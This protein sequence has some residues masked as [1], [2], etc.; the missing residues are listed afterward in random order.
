MTCNRT[1]TINNLLVALHAC[2]CADSSSSDLPNRAVR[3]DNAYGYICE[4]LRAIAAHVELE[5]YVTTGDLV[6]Y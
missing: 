1:E 6:T 4:A 2:N 3:Q 5:A